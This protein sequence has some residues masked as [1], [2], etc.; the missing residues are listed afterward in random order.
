MQI[1]KW[2]LALGLILQACASPSTETFTISRS[3]SEWQSAESRIDLDAQRMA[4]QRVVSASV[5]LLDALQANCQ[6][7][8]LLR[9]TYRLQIT[10]S[11]EV[12]AFYRDGT[13]RL[14]RG[15]V[16]YTRN[17]SEI[18]FVL[19]HELAHEI[20]DHSKQRGLSRHEKEMAAD[21]LAAK[22]IA[23]AGFQGKQAI[24][25][26]G[27]LASKF[28]DAHRGTD[29]P[30]YA[31]RYQHLQL[32]MAKTADAQSAISPGICNPWPEIHIAR[33]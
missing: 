27:R 19:A 17:E 23:G 32:S 29:Y 33:K 26:L 6:S 7:D 1:S 22:M 14:T 12:N 25:L 28:P 13:V 15:M 4:T 8:R 21:G 18:A 16:H 24:A 11:R 10:N 3:D 2:A 9:S 30:S 5:Q 20:L 31:S